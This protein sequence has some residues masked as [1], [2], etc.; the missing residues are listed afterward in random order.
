MDDKPSSVPRD[1]D[2]RLETSPIT[3][4]DALGKC[5]EVGFS[6]LFCHTGWMGGLPLACS[7]VAIGLPLWP[8]P[9]KNKFTLVD[10]C[11]LA[12]KCM[13]V[14]TSICTKRQSMQIGLLTLK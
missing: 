3:A 13:S 1:I 6:K 12:F 5:V 2:L 11:L 8:A 4:I 14:A 9:A 7:I 10:L